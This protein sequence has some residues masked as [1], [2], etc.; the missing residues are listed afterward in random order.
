MSLSCGMAGQEAID[1]PYREQVRNAFEFWK[2]GDRQRDQ[3]L[4]KVMDFKSLE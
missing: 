4:K 1:N 2:K 3:K